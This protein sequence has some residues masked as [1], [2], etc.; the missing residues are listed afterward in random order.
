MSS[1]HPVTQGKICSARWCGS[2]TSL[3]LGCRAGAASPWH[4]PRPPWV[5]CERPRVSDPWSVASG[6]F[7]QEFLP[8]NTGDTS[9]LVTHCYFKNLIH[10][11]NMSTYTA[12]KKEKKWEW[13]AGNP[14]YW[15]CHS[16]HPKPDCRLNIST[17]C[18][19]F[20]CVDPSHA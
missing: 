1:Y 3:F 19:S 7:G 20:F 17:S 5:T 2:C 16:P 8:I 11:W 14:L 15:W 9:C 6:F 12:W 18:F 4:R 13:R 10:C